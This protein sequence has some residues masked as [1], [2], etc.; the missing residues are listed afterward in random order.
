M[1][2][3]QL[4]DRFTM[5]ALFFVATVLIVEKIVFAFLGYGGYR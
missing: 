1:T 5:P 2:K 4:L 3:G